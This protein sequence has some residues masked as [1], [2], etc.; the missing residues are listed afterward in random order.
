[1]GRLERRLRKLEDRAEDRGASPAK[2]E[3]ARL[4]RELQEALS[5]LSDDELYALDAVLGATIEHTRESGTLVDPYEVPDELSGQSLDLFAEL[6]AELSG[7]GQ[8]P[9]ADP[10]GSD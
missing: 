3:Q 1:V 8:P 4:Q 5:R 7:G 2:L 9:S 10:L 6:L